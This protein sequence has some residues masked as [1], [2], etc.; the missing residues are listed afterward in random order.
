[1]SGAIAAARHEQAL[2]LW[3][4][5]AD[6]IPGAVAQPAFRLL[7]CHAGFGAKPDCADA[8]RAYAAD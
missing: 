1:M 5:H 7:R 4:R 8:F 6:E 3:D 2:A